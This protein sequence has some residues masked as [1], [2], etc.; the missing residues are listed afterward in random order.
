MQQCSQTRLLCFL[1]CVSDWVIAGL[2]WDQ[3]SA[4]RPWHCC[5]FLC[6]FICCLLSWLSENHYY[7]GPCVCFGPELTGWG[8]CPEN[9]NQ[10]DSS[11]VWNI[12]SLLREYIWSAVVEKH[13]R[14]VLTGCSAGLCSAFSRFRFQYQYLSIFP[15][16]SS[17][18]KFSLMKITPFPGPGAGWFQ[19]YDQIHLLW[20]LLISVTQSDSRFCV[21]EFMWSLMHE[22]THDLGDCGFILVLNL[23]EG[24]SLYLLSFI[25]NTQFI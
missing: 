9:W 4:L 18:V 14:S 1:G 7:P 10:W 16:A 2:C 11:G 22:Q 21:E 19:I 15:R 25:I 8:W 20:G 17:A 12:I 24:W 3:D 6:S 5:A 13:I 23:T